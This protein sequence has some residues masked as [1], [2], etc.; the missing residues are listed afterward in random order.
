MDLPA[1]L[2]AALER[3]GDATRSLQHRLARDP[4]RPMW[5]LGPRLS[6]Q[7]PQLSSDVDALLATLP[8]LNAALAEAGVSG[9]TLHE[10]VPPPS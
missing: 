8:G 9:L 10:P 5:S 7:L 3:A 4:S 2:G 1:A 6:E